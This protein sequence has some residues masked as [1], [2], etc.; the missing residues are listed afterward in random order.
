MIYK[1]Y[2]GGDFSMMDKCVMGFVI[3]ITYGILTM[4]GGGVFFGEN[5][6]IPIYW[7]SWI[8]YPLLGIII[9]FLTGAIIVSIGWICKTINEKIKNK[10]KT[11]SKIYYENGTKD[12][13]A[14]IRG[15]YC[16][17]ITWLED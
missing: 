3:Y 4:F 13:W 15:K 9:V 1:H 8:I 11:N 12:L 6:T 5:G 17:K 14:S 16:T 7:W 10:Q 2:E